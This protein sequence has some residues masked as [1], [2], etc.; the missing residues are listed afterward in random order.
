MTRRG[1]HFCAR[2]Q[3]PLG[4]RQER[5][6]APDG[7]SWARPDMWVHPTLDPDCAPWPELNAAL[8]LPQRS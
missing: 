7:G 6:K 4:A 2:C 5:L 1:T 8:A 3:K